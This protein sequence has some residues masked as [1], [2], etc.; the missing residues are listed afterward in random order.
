MERGTDLMGRAGD[1]R[2]ATL[3]TTLRWSYQLP[4]ERERTA[5]VRLAV[6]RGAFSFAAATE[7]CSDQAAGL[8][9]AWCL[10]ATGNLR[11]G[12]EAL[13]CYEESAA[14]MRRLGAERELANVLYLMATRIIK[15]RGE[16]DRAED[17]YRESLALAERSGSRQDYAH[18]YC[19]LGQ[20]ARLRGDDS[21]AT[22]LL[23]DSQRLLSECGDRICSARVEAGLGA[24]AVRDGDEG[25]AWAWL[26]R[27]SRTAVAVGDPSATAL[28]IVAELRAA[29]G[30]PEE[31]ARLLGCAVAVRQQLSVSAPAADVGSAAA[32][33][34]A[35]R[36]LLGAGQVDALLSEGDGLDAACVA[37]SLLAE[38]GM[39]GDDGE[40]GAATFDGSFPRR[41]WYR[42][43]AGS[44]TV[45]VSPLATGT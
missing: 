22:A 11:T 4:D 13:A 35:L 42:V 17:L 29:A 5:F 23:S 10:A 32:L 31:A 14:L 27:G 18:A 16:F 21:L 36:I 19:E 20:V 7:A 39:T 43:G 1:D 3:Y 37:A 12:D 28:A 8:A 33:A 45:K 6:F 2:Q 44:R 9:E 41:G 30:L 24:L 34:D 38:R 40:P 25:R 15:P 26:L